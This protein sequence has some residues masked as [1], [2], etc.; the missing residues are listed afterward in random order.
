[1]TNNFDKKLSDVV[2]QLVLSFRNKLKQ[3]ALEIYDD[4]FKNDRVYFK[5][6]TEIQKINS[7]INK[8]KDEIKVLEN[9]KLNLLN[10]IKI[11]YSKISND[12]Q[13][14]I[15]TIFSIDDYHL[16]SIHVKCIELVLK[17]K[18]YFNEQNFLSM[19]KDIDYTMSIAIGKEKRNLFLN[20]V[21]QD[22][23]SLGIDIPPYNIVNFSKPLVED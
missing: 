6:Y 1:M 4:H 22:W 19:I 12:K 11:D 10:L 5:N 21:N 2:S 7:N 15:K 14:I 13:R 8:L 20:F 23:K 17:T 16:N 9:N 18:E 3:K